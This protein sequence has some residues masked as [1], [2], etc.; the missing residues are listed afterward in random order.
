MSEYLRYTYALDERELARLKA[1]LSA[2]N[3]ALPEIEKTPCKVLD[4]RIPIGCATPDSWNQGSCK[5]RGS[6]YRRSGQAGKYLVGSAFRLE[7]FPGGTV[8]TETNFT[9]PRLPG[10]EEQLE[11]IQSKVY[12]SEKPV[13]WEN[14]ESSEIME[15]FKDF[16][17]MGTREIPALLK[18]LKPLGLRGLTKATV[19]FREIFVTNCANHAN[20]MDPRYFVEENGEKIPYSISDNTLFICSACAE[21]FDLVG[22]GFKTKLVVPCLG[23][24]IY[25][26]MRINRYHQVRKL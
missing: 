7:G 19:L 8:I 23:A 1:E 24:A 11:L 10:R 25:G 21:Y 3:Q 18:R 5:R 13:D 6:W 12:Q 14:V 17:S 22:S 26:I 2:R 15:L 20:F 4:P 16:K 9:P